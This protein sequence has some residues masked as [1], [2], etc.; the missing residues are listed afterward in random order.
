MAA[1]LL[2]IN[3]T[4]LPWRPIFPY[5]FVQVAAVARRHGLLVEPLDLLGV[6]KARWPSFLAHHVER[7]GPRM[8]GLHIRQGDSVFIEDYLSPVGGSTK[9]EYFPI[10][11]NHHLVSV[12]R[13]ISDVPIIVGGFGFSTHAE[14]LFDH[15]G[16]DFGVH[17]DP[18]AVFARFEDLLARRNLSSVENLI[19]R[20]NVV[21]RN[22][23][24]YFAPH[25]DIE[26]DDRLFD[27]LVRFYGHR[28]LF[29]GNPPTVAVEIMRGCPFR[30]F[31]CTE[32]HVKGRAI[33]YRSLEV[34]EAEIER[35]VRRQIW[36]F[37]LVCSELDVQGL[38]FA[39]QLAE[40]IARLRTRYNLPI[41]WSAYALPRLR[42]DDLRYLQRAGYVGA[43]NDV[44]SL[45]DANLRRAG[46]PYRTKQALVFLKAV[47]ALDREDAASAAN[48][49]VATDKIRAGLTQRTPK[50]LASIFGLFLGNAHATPTTI[51]E[52]LRVIDEHNLRENYKG[53]LAFPSTR[54]FAPDGI[55]ICETTSR[56]LRTFGPDGIR[57]PDSVHPTFYFPDFLVDRLGS[58]EAVMAFMQY[59]G[60]TFMSV[61]HRA[62]QDWIW[63]LSH[64]IGMA[65]FSQLVESSGLVSE[66]ELANTLSKTPTPQFLRVLYA[67]TVQD[68][69][70]VNSA[71][72]ALVEHI[73]R[74]NQLEL[75]A[76][77]KRAGLPETIT[78]YSLAREVYARFDRLGDFVEH[79]RPQSAL[80]RLYIDWLVFAHNLRIVPAYRELLFGAGA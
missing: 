24:G 6:P 77:K 80:E 40:R 22:S 75:A 41:E 8:I 39:R 38:G 13:S 1:D 31:F 64:H 55:A 56:G 20:E 5:A 49:A 67:P 47:V 69:A 78:E 34:V 23:R 35:L 12:L 68:H 21:V 73:L 57:D 66:P 61:G 58:P 62:R 54:V 26:Y 51:S 79:A 16:I 43:L 4:N 72:K 59:V 25:E 70:K 19:F 11:D 29:G 46:V 71:A 17:G 3:A 33:R 28:E 7:V 14:R 10:D 37:W 63:F 42:E 60:E 52:T 44:L 45:E 9:R 65:E 32:P 27:H 18:D 76:I 48:A 15:L 74:T 2:L 36:R 30:C 50:E 53:G